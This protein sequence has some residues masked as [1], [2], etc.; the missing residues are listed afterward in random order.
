MST[1]RIGEGPVHAIT[2][3]SNGLH[4]CHA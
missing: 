1:D 4:E 3:Y 2:R